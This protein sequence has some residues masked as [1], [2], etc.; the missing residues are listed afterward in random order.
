MV[1]YIAIAIP[2]FFVLIGIE[3]LVARAQGKSVYRFNDAIADLSCGISQ[4]VT[5]LFL[6]G[7]L[8]A[9]YLLVYEQWAVLEMSMASPW[10]WILAIVAVDFLYYWWHRTSHVVNLMWAA[11]IVHHQSED[12]NFAVALR[13]AWFTSATAWIF[14]IPLAVLGV[15]PLVFLGA[16]AFSTLY[17]FWIH[18]ETIDKLGP[19]EWVLN[20]PSHHRVHHAINPHYLERN[21]AA[22][23]I[24]WDRM[25]GSF[26]R[27]DEQPVYGI[28]E[29]LASWNPVWANFHY[30]K[31]IL[32][33]VRRARTP[34][35]KLRV[36]FAEPGWDPATDERPTPAPVD[37]DTYEKFDTD[38]PRPLTMY[39]AFQFVP[40]AAATFALLMWQDAL[41]QTLSFVAAFAILL[42]V[43]VW[44]GLLE[45]KA[46]AAPVEVGRLLLVGAGIGWLVVAG[47]LPLSAATVLLSAGLFFIGWIAAYREEFLPRARASSGSSEA[48]GGGGLQERS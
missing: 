31:E 18:T 47:V 43:L 27:E 29:P 5:G 24:V 48:L 11:H 42:S 41:G 13:Q 16:D 45:R 26:Q 25:F 28:L 44:G 9:G 35:D 22:V 2:V 4:Q 34:W 15:P 23:F 36:W 40:I 3:L 32:Q 14:Y 7:V 37:P 20:T 6:K 30:F 8:F 39:V 10:T 21:Y 17:Q 46:W 1:N 33:K 12:M 38:V 19:L